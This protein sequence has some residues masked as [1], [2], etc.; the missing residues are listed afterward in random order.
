M[1]QSQTDT[2]VLVHLIAHHFKGDLVSAVRDALYLAEGS[3]AICVVEQSHPDTIV[4]ARKD[5][6]LI[7][8]L[9]E[10]ENFVASDIPAILKYTRRCYLLDDYEMALITPQH[11][12]VLDRNAKPVSKA[13]FDVNWDENAAERGGYAHFMLKESTKRIKP[14]AKRWRR[15]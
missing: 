6:P 1:F 14:S 13:V 2:E 10:G 5:S 15:G 12:T 11:V 4:C 7:I 3:Y 8:G 9:G